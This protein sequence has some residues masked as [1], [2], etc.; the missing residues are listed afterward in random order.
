MTARIRFRPRRIE[1]SGD[2]SP[3]SSL[4]TFVVRMTGCWQIVACGLSLVVT[5]LALAP[6]ELQRRLIDD[7]VMKS[8]GGLVITLGLIYL[9]VI[10]LHQASKFA[11]AMLQSWMSESAIIYTRRHLWRLRGDEPSPNGE[12]RDIVNV[13]S[14]EVEA[15]GGFAGA[16]P[17]QALANAAMLLGGLGYMFYVQPAVALCGLALLAPQAVLAPLMQRRLNRLISIQVRLKRRYAAAIGDEAPP[18]R[19]EMKIRTGHLFRNRMTFVLWKTMLKA[20]LNLLNAAAPVA[21]LVVGGLMVIAGQ[22]TV[23]VI[24]S[25]VGGFNRL[26]EPVRQLIA[27]YREAAEAGVRHDMVAEWMT[28][29]SSSDR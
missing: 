15:L 6:I 9:G 27:F 17:S 21:V 3:A 25:F 29:S 2:D 4:R 18:D 10:L 24:I 1:R 13:L 16:A 11:L 14:I 26:A 22:S 19:K 20:G 7:G 5:G 12:G 8:D 23:G 28:S